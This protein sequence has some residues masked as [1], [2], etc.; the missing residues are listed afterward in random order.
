MQEDPIATYDEARFDLRRH[1]ELF[2]D[3]VRVTGRG[4]PWGQFDSTIPLA[5][6]Q[7]HVNRLWVRG[8][9]F[10]YGQIALACALGAAVGLVFNYGTE[11]LATP[12]AMVVIG[13]IA[14]VGLVLLLPNIRAVEFAR[15]HTDAGLCG[16]DVGRVGPSAEEFD[17]FVSSLTQLIAGA[18]SK[19]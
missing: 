9:L 13:S 16:L 1:F 10:R 15:F 17:Q 3:R 14:A 2:P 19:S 5:T 7:P 12:L 4:Q 18:R 6:L 11:I 8:K